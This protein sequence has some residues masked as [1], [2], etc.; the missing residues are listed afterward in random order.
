MF[1]YNNKKRILNILI[2]FIILILIYIAA[3]SLTT[4][5][6]KKLIEKNTE[7]SSLQLENDK[8]KSYA[9]T[10]FYRETFTD[11]VML[12][13]CYNLDENNPFR[14]SLENHI[15][16]NYEDGVDSYKEFDGVESLQSEF[17]PIYDKYNNVKYTYDYEYSRYWHGYLIFLRPLL[18]F[19]SYHQ[20]S[21]LNGIVFIILLVYLEI[22]I[23]KKLGKK[24]AIL[25]FFLINS[26][27]YFYLWK[28]ISLVPTIIIMMIFSIIILKDKFK[29]VYLLFLINGSLMAYF[30]WFNFNVLALGLPLIFYYLL[31]PV[32]EYSYKEFIKICL[33]WLCSYF[34]TWILKWLITDI[35]CGTSIIKDGF[36]QIVFRMSSKNG[37]NEKITLISTFFRNIFSY[38][39]PIKIII[40]YIF[41]ISLSNIL[42]NNVI[43][44]LKQK[45][46]MI[47]LSIGA[48]PFIVYI[49]AMNHSYIHAEMF[50]YRMLLLTAYVTVLLCEKKFNSN[51]DKK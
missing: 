1:I 39:L 16:S 45:E 32:E 17:N 37:N 22:L 7:K 15:H 31:K 14:S 42:K 46:K 9:G 30:T 38:Y 36:N 24:I 2:T 12:S 8:L 18:I 6:P 23:N 11:A 47:F 43:L 35:F 5:I 10:I 29:D 41:Y 49:F 51:I 40:I 28:S 44:P 13:L 4:K 19:F 50:N 26:I 25:N 34:F 3:L 48:M 27:G 33:I 20:I 21:I